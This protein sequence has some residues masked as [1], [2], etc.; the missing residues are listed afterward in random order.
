MATPS[1]ASRQDEFGRVVDA[2]QPA[3]GAVRYHTAD[4]LNTFNGFVT[5][6]PSGVGLSVDARENG[7][8]V[9]R[10]ASDGNDFEVPA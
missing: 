8:I 7:I 10:S 2:W 5:G 6:G 1:F 3:T 4:D 9:I